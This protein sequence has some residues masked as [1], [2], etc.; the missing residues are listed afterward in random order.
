MSTYI[1]H[2]T[3]ISKMN[4]SILLR[5]ISIFKLTFTYSIP[6]SEEGMF[7]LLILYV[8]ILM[9]ILYI[10]VLYIYVYYVYILMYILY[11]TIICRISEELYKKFQRANNLISASIFLRFLCTTI[12]SPSLFKLIQ[13]YPSDKA[14]QRLTLIAK[15]IK[16][17][18]DFTQ[19]GCKEEFMF[20]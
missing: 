3:Y 9:Y 1:I 10:Y 17:I 14:V 5:M 15:A 4:P 8:Y 16:K 20:F 19:F 2:Y 18:A 7:Y 13:E 12:L 11:K 6:A